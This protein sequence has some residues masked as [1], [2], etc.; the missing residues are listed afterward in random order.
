MTDYGI[1]SVGE[2]MGTIIHS[3]PKMTECELVLTVPISINI[4][5]LDGITLADVSRHL[6]YCLIKQES[7][8]PPF[9]IE[10]FLHSIHQIIKDA[11]S[12]AVEENHEE[13]YPGTVP[14]RTE[15]STGETAC[16]LLT[17]KRI[18]RR[19]THYTTSCWKAALK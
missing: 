4:E 9:E 7:N 19:I 18:V 15:N 13:K 12:S 10:M 1:E 2:R 17:S 3:L 14:Y 6:N 11:I 5:E 16:W 8:H